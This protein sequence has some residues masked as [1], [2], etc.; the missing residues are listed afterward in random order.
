MP[1]LIIV[2]MSGLAG[3]GLWRLV[4]ADTITE[5]LRIRL[6]RPEGWWDRFLGCPWCSGTWYAWAALTIGTIHFGMWPTTFTGGLW[7]GVQAFAARI[8]TGYVG[9]HV[10]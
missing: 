10:A 8:V 4:A 1:D 3:A 7:F 9:D 5:P 6:I 2:L